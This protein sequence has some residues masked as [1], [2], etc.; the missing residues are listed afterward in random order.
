MFCMVTFNLP[1]AVDLRALYNI[2]NLQCQFQL[3]IGSGFQAFHAMFELEQ[4]TLNE[5]DRI[6]NELRKN[7]CF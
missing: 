7:A 6:R 2:G 3:L 5:S 1:L 4:C